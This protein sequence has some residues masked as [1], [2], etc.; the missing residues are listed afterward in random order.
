MA[1]WGAIA[2]VLVRI[3]ES[4]TM[5]VD[6]PSSA[7][8]LLST[9]AALG[10]V[11]ITPAWRI[12]RHLVTIAHEGAHGVAALLTGRRLEG[13][14]LHSD[15]SGLTVSR[16]RPTGPGMVVTLFAGY[17]G[18]ALVGLGV[19]ALLARGYALGALWVLVLLLGLL[20]LQIRNWFGLWSVLVSATALVLVSWFA[21]PGVSAAAAFLV[22][23]FL[24][25][26]SVRP[27]FELQ[28]SRRRRGAA[29]IGGGGIELA[30][31]G[32]GPGVVRSDADQLARLTRVP[33]VLWVGAFLIVNVGC[34]LLGGSWLWPR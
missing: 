31:R 15:T 10:A 2:G 5:P 25:L 6:P 24:L 21:P 30:R 17:A 27:V 28:G 3:W 18:P 12:A 13:I 7:V 33:A 19:A 16:G 32:G 26:G 20:L 34:L 4:A 11:V 22:G 29:G 9:L 23:W 1:V 8:L 14:R